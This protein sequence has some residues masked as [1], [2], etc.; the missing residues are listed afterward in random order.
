[1]KAHTGGLQVVE[2]SV[3]C[4]QARDCQQPLEAKRKAGVDSPLEPSERAW[5]CSH[6]G[7]RLLPS[8][9]GR[10]EIPVV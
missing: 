10:Q 6:L 3:M 4:L 7:C 1:M 5:V 9:A 8:R 2:V